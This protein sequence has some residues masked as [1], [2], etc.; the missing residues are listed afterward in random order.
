MR[1][2]HGGEGRGAA[3]AG[4]GMFEGPGS[5]SQGVREAGGGVMEAAGLQDQGR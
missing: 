5:W 3:R 4:A 2:D 1:N